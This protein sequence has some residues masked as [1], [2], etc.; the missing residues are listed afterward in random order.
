MITTPG[1]LVSPT[2][3]NLLLS[4]F[5]LHVICSYLFIH[6]SQPTSVKTQ[7]ETQ[8]TDFP[9]FKIENAKILTFRADVSSP[10]LLFLETFRL[11]LNTLD[12]SVSIRY[13]G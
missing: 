1:A 8:K 7:K 9:R 6:V 2:L 4:N 5:Y 10:S 3:S 12:Q 13:K 11:Y